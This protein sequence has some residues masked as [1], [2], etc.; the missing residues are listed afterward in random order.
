MAVIISG[1]PGVGKTFFTNA[2]TAYRCA[3]SDSSQ[4]SW[5]SDGTRNPNFLSDYLKHIYDIVEKQG[6]DIIFVSSHKDVR[7]A[8][9]KAG[10]KFTMVYPCVSLKQEYLERYRR[11]GSPQAFIDLM[12]SKWEEFIGCI[13]SM[14]LRYVCVDEAKLTK[15]DSYFQP[16]D[17]IFLREER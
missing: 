12:E 9:C 14:C 15:H 17:S 5:L 3:D 11:R 7:D 6:H 10:I 16:R 13:E 8:L 1:F 4:F 2:G